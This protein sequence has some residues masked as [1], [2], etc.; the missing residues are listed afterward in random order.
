MQLSDTVGFFFSPGADFACEEVLFSFW[1][2]NS[3]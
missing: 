1:G 2:L 3:I